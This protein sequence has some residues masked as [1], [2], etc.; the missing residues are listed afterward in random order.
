MKS[1]CVLSGL[2]T[3]SSKPPKHQLNN[4]L[5][6]GGS[7]RCQRNLRGPSA[8][9][10]KPSQLTV[11]HIKARARAR[12]LRPEVGS[13]PDLSGV[14]DGRLLQHGS[15]SFRGGRL[16]MGVLE[17]RAGV[18]PAHTQDRS[19]ALLTHSFPTG[20]GGRVSHQSTMSLVPSSVAAL[21]TGFLSAH[22]L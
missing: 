2:G 9:P 6:P 19:S 15:Q 13:E 10:L 8:D 12:A 17:P 22:A 3:D 21:M 16:L 1:V 4:T 5:N 7:Q 14:R 18:A 11:K 20:R